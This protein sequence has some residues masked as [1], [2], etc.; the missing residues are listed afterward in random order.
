ME[1]VEFLCFIVDKRDRGPHPDNIEAVRQ[2]VPPKNVVQLRSLLSLAI[3]I[4]ATNLYSRCFFSPHQ[5]YPR[6]SD[7]CTKWPKDEISKELL[8]FFSRRESLSVVDNCLLTGD[9]VVVPTELRKTK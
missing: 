3:P 6:E 8:Q 7:D 9:R 2:M 5:S 1:S 4:N